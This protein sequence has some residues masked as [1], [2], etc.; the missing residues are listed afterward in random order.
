MP[1]RVEGYAIVSADGMLADADRH[2]PDSIKVDADQTFFQGSLDQ[3]A[4]VVHG[5]HSHEGGPRAGRRR[6]LILTHDT[7]AIAPDAKHPNALLW[8]PAG[9][10]FE[11]A[12][13]A[14]GVEDG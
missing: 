8:N 5:R 7:D 14:L 12:L 10:T 13:R 11:Q 3:V 1:L 9:A 2:M 6:R 4:A